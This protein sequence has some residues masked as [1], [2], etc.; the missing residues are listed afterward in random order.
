MPREAKKQTNLIKPEKAPATK[1]TVGYNYC[2]SPRTTP[3]FAKQ[4]LANKQHRRRR[5]ETKFNFTTINK[6]TGIETDSK[7][8]FDY[9]IKF[10]NT[11]I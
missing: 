5:L 9:A 8:L 7:A 3:S 6:G 10:E 2:L 4:R 11:R 1:S